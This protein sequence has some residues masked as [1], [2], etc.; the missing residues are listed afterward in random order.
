MRSNTEAQKRSEKEN[1][2]YKKR[3]ET[4]DIALEKL[5]KEKDELWAIV[6]TDKFK[7]I[8]TVE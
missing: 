3:V 2:D 8:R 1:Y 4:K 6:N 5:R 7:S